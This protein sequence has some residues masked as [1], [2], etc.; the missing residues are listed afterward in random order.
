MKEYVYV[1][2]GDIE[3]DDEII[4]ELLYGE[5]SIIIEIEEMK[6]REIYKMDNEVEIDSK[7]L[8]KKIRREDYK[9]IIKEDGRKKNYIIM[10]EEED[11]E[12]MMY[13]EMIEYIMNFDKKEIV[14][15]EIREKKKEEIKEE[16][17]RWKMIGEYVERYIE[18]GEKYREEYIERISREY[19]EKNKKR[20]MK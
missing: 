7:M 11:N 8:R 19:I 12:K 10:T 15:N 9:N 13:E 2:I 14:G 3:G 16:I 6:I 1:I 20:I 18:K 4:K 17:K 5:V